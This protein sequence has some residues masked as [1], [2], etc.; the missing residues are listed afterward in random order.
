[1][2]LHLSAA[3]VRGP[4][5]NASRERRG[6]EYAYFAFILV[7][8]G[9]AGDLIP[10]LGSLPLAKLAMG[11]A[12]IL[13]FA[14]WK[15][16]PKL[17]IVATPLI[18]TLWWLAA[19][20]IVTTPFSIWP[21][22]S[23][24]FLRQELPILAATILL[25][26]KISSGWRQVRNI[27]AVLVIA[28]LLNAVSAVWGF[29]GGRAR[30]STGAYD[31]NDLAYLLVSVLP[32]ALAF[33]LCAKSKAGRIWFAGIAGIVTVAVLLTSSRGGFLGL[34]AV[35]AFLVLV[36]VKRPRARPD[37]SK[38]RRRVLSS[39][40]GIVCLAAVI[41]PNLPEETQAHLATIM[42][43]EKDYNTDA[44][45]PNSRSSIWRRNFDAV[46]H[47]P[48]GFGVGAFAMVDVR[49]G[50]KFRA[51]HNSYIEALVELGFLGLF[52]FLRVYV[53]AWR[54]LQR[55]RQ[56][57]LSAPP[58][59]TG[60]EA[61]VFA[62]MMQA[63]LIGNAVAGFFLSMAYSLVLWTLVS[64]AIALVC[65]VAES[66]ARNLGQSGPPAAQASGLP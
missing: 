38:A 8:V 56:A 46:L 40:L 55:A 60:D 41:W 61:L 16:L 32:L 53:L 21:G 15:Q 28:G 62:R 57:L 3:P 39:L 34:L 19:L 6:L 33:A 25:T 5:T 26:C 10:G 18:R 44:T 49:S 42:S 31:T 54:S 27:G 52:L 23:I 13:L 66:S 51:P 1:M 9:R 65:V 14:R 36:P 22:A 45:N 29:H 47:R 12:L 35:V 17:P 58:S 50:G 63:G 59:A 30:S 43:L 37:G 64:A 20:T 4:E 7:A 2:D 48:I 11:L 24:E